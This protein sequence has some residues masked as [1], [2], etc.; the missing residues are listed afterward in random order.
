MDAPSIIQCAV[1]REP[2]P[3]TA[4]FCSN[5]GN[6]N[7]SGESVFKEKHGFTTIKT[8][9]IK[10]PDCGKAVSDDANWCLNCGKV[11]GRPALQRAIKESEEKKRKQQDERRRAQEQIDRTNAAMQEELEA[12]GA[13][14]FAEIDRVD[15]ILNL[16]GAAC[17]VFIL[18]AL[19]YIAWQVAYSASSFF[20]GVGLFLII[21][22]VGA[23]GVGGGCMFLMTTLHDRAV[24]ASCSSPTPT[25]SE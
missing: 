7:Q 10:C 13:E 3:F 15:K 8:H 20:A 9:I 22:A 1:C 6:A 25:D 23:V 16:V 18:V 11:I 21:W 19:P 14:R 2:L 12:K 4:K 24:N 5:C 17:V